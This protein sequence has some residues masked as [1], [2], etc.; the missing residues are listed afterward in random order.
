MPCCERSC[1]A[2][3]LGDWHRVAIEAV[4]RFEDRASLQRLESD[5][6]VIQFQAA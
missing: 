5:G 2:T 4:K 6:S 1:F 3:I